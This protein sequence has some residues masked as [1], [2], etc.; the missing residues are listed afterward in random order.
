MRDRREP[1]EPSLVQRRHAALVALGASRGRGGQAARGCRSAS[2]F[3][4]VLAELGVD[5]ATVDAAFYQRL[6]GG[7]PRPRLVTKE[8]RDKASRYRRLRDAGAS[9]A[10]ATE[11]KH[12]EWAYRKGLKLLAMGVTA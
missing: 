4:R 8:A 3:L 1:S 5:A 2:A 6:T 11:Y 7:Y 9:A 12:S 10:F